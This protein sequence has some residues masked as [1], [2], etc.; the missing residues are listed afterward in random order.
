MSTKSKPQRRG[1]CF[2]MGSKPAGM[3]VG[4]DEIKT[5]VWDAFAPV[6][7][8]VVKFGIT[9]QFDEVTYAQ[10]LDDLVRRNLC[11]YMDVDHATANLGWS[12][13]EVP[14]LA[15]Y[16]CVQVNHGGELWRRENLAGHTCADAVP[17]DPA[18]APEGLYAFRCA[19]TPKGREKLPN[20]Q[21]LSIHFD[22]FGED[23]AGHPVGQVLICVGAVNGPQIPGALPAGGTFNRSDDMSVKKRKLYALAQGEGEG[24]DGAESKDMSAVMAEIAKVCGLPDG[25]EP[26]AV[27]GAVLAILMAAK[28]GEPDGDEPMGE[29]E[30]ADGEM[31]ADALKYMGDEEMKKFTRRAAARFAR[32]GKLVQVFAKQLGCKA[33]PK[34]V[35]DSFLTF[36]AKSVDT[37]E[38]AKIKGEVDAL[39][40]ERAAE[41]AALRKGQIDQLFSAVAGRLP[42]AKIDELRKQAE[43]FSATPEQVKAW[44]PD[45]TD[46]VYTT[47]GAPAGKGG[48]AQGSGES[49]KM[50]GADQAAA[51]QVFRSQ[52][53]KDTG[54]RLKHDMAGRI[55]G[56]FFARGAAVKYEEAKAQ[57]DR[58]PPD[59]FLKGGK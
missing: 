33:T 58:L 29:G 56:G 24:G 50:R 22:P 59:A 5:Q 27:L 52:Y 30:M 46:V 49:D 14:A 34:A 32:P 10:M 37:G 48:P 19:V 54:K 17:L 53:E 41:K 23:M 9:S 55:V 7:G 2:D 6:W 3:F 4:S 38:F 12:V 39:K 21:A 40:F 28:P 47:G 51:I 45:V 35:L 11:V 15:Y 18:A 1:L 43:A 31:P 42:E 36:R 25:A 20:Y 26:E 13:D 16:C 44:L 8:P 57:A